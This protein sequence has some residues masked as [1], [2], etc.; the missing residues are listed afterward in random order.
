MVRRPADSTLRI[1]FSDAELRE[2]QQLKMSLGLSV[3]AFAFLSAVL[4]A[5]VGFRFIV[6]RPL[7]L[8]Q[9]A[10]RHS[11]TTG[12][13]L[14]I[15]IHG[16]DEIGAIT[17]AFDEMIRREDERETTLRYTNAM[18]Q[19]SEVLLTRNN[20]RL[21]Q[22]VHERT[23]ELVHEKLRA[24]AANEAKSRFVWIT[25]HELRTPLNAIIGF[26]EMMEHRMFGPLGHRRYDGYARDI[27]MSGRHLL[28]IIDSVLD[29]AKIESGNE[30]L[31]EEVVDVGELMGDCLSVIQPLCDSS[32]VT[33]DS[34][35]IGTPVRLTIDRTRIKQML[36]NLL[37]NGVKF[38]PK[39]GRIE[40]AAALCPD[41]G[42][43]FVVSDTGIG[44]REEDIPTALSTFGQFDNSL[45]RR[46]NGTGLGLHLARLTVE[47]H[48]GNLSIVSAPGRGCRVT[49][50][51][52]KDRV[53]P[54]A[55]Q[56]A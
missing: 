3:V 43:E 46:Q 1:R 13:R 20:E 51:L 18:L 11:T 36:I 44:M 9:T 48:G 25:S 35:Q 14:P 47:M 26:A 55:D 19:A 34:L 5:F 37:G 29:I 31:H 39:G 12:E 30:T 38:T 17:R 15:G 2:F 33:L 10:I 27:R 50:R 6:G 56:T 41:G 42:I 7:H 8:L 45:S 23:V 4:A 54:A 40:L 53:V 16:K 49:V 52:Q 24:E 21:E 22:R 32:G 28:A